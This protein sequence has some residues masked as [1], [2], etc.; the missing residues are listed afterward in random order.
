M[1]A[2]QSWIFQWHPIYCCRWSILSEKMMWSFRIPFQWRDDGNAYAARTT[3]S[4]VLAPGSCRQRSHR[5]STTNP[6]YCSQYLLCIRALWKSI[7]CDPRLWRID[8][9]KYCFVFKSSSIQTDDKSNQL[10]LISSYI[11]QFQCG[12]QTIYVTTVLFEILQQQLDTIRCGS[13]KWAG[14]VDLIAD[15]RHETL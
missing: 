12:L 2:R 8:T 5:E 4:A 11:L 3:R 6:A 7:G 10:P 9:W 13:G 15:R 14:T 1:L